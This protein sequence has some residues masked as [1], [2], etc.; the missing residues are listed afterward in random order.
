M[1]YYDSMYRVDDIVVRTTDCPRGATS[2]KEKNMI[3]IIIE[4][5][6]D[7]D[8]GKK[9]YRLNNLYFYDDSELRPATTSEMKLFIHE[10]ALN[11]KNLVEI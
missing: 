11:Y 4:S 5:R 2:E 9:V 8:S 6:R 1:D 7:I 10:M 3:G